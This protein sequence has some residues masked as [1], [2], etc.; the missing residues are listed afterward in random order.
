MR[1]LAV[2]DHPMI[3]KGVRSFLEARDG[4]ELCGEAVDGYEA[5]AKA[6][7]LKPD[8]ILMDIS[9]PG[10]N[11]L[12]AT[13]EILR[14]L[15]R[16]RV[17]ILSQHDAPEM[18]RQ[19]LNAGAR[20]YVNKSAIARDLL[21][22]LSQIGLSEASPP[23]VVLGSQGEDIDAKE[24]LQRSSAFETALRQTE[25][26]LRRLVEYQSAV[27]NNMA[28][29]LYTLDANG[30]VT[31]INPAGEAIL[32]WTRD[33]LLGKKMHD[34]TH[35]QHPDGSP[36]PASECPGLHVL[37]EGIALRE[38]EDVFIRKDGSFVP[39]VFSASPLRED[40]KITGVIVGFRDDT[41]QRQA[42][43][44]LLQAKRELGNV[45]DRL[46]FVTDT[47]AAAVAWCNRDFRY[48]WA[49]QSLSDLL[50]VPLAEIV[51]R[52]I[53]E[54]LGEEAF[55]TLLPHFQD[56]LAGRKVSYEEE[57]VYRGLERKWISA[58][59]TPTF[60]ASGAPDGWVAVVS[61]I[62]DRKREEEVLRQS[63][64][65]FRALVRATSYFT[66]R[67]NPDWTEIKQL[68]E[69]GLL[70]ETDELKAN[71]L[72]EYIHP[73]DQPVV[74]EKAQQAI[75][76]KGMFELEHRVRRPDGT[77]GWTLSRAVPILNEQGEVV[78]W[79]GT[80]ADVTRHKQANSLCAMLRSSSAAFSIPRP[81]A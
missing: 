54:V 33:E 75:R 77:V 22:V 34:V 78:E 35:Y 58:T 52:P 6:Q 16:T 19:A 26:R 36:Y 7:E 10:M 23:P 4:F 37:Q 68:D 70:S 8:L 39:V 71:W 74:I 17:V 29:G 25:H 64:D 43:E 18:M 80:A 61:D 31:S 67:L 45:K 12:D 53:S 79:F 47:M 2:D 3:R 62:T 81:R 13:R 50:Q 72:E 15:P 73:A 5:V 76:S 11:G 14:Q 9:M 20:A 44:A 28:E 30:L 60:D 66:C 49:N 27:M 56:V 69:R 63:A 51:G 32:G 42:K 46:Q 59:Y 55:Q 40:D 65:R 21:G 57:L 41:E 1:I 38:H 48:L 24:L